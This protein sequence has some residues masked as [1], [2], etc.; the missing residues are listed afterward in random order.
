[1]NDE[2]MILDGIK[3]L[4]VASFIAGPVATTVMAD[5]GAKVIKVEPPAGD[6]Y[7]DL[8]GLAGMPQAE[9]PYHLLVD[10][11]GK[12][13][14]CL[15]LTKEAGRGVLFR[16]VK[17]TDVLVT[18]YM[19]EVREKLGLCYEELAEVNPRL[20]YGSMSAYG[21]TGPEAGQTGFDTTAY[22]A[23]SGLMD[24]VRP[25]PDGDPARSMPGQGDHPTGLA[26]FSA[27]LLALIRRER[28]GEGSMVHSSLLA[29]GYWANAYM[30]QAALCGAEVPL[31][32]RRE[33]AVNAL[34]NYYKSKD[35][36][37]LMLTAA[38]E[39]KEWAR[40]PKALGRPD[41]MDD[42][43]FAS[44]EERQR[45]AETL[46][47]ILDEV[48]G[49]QD[50][51]FWREAFREYRVTAGFVSKTED[52]V[53]DEQAIKSGALASGTGAGLSMNYVIDSPLWVDGS[54]KQAP[55]PAPEHGE[56][57]LEILTEA[58]Y[59]KAGIADLHTRGAFGSGG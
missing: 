54:P 46:T 14:L 58:G 32:P 10:N 7:R 55:S 45:N 49:G 30:A 3:V 59:D 8:P 15:D 21:E 6:G 50:S 51:A 27:I 40:L 56:H 11:R 53:S 44:Q 29:N 36:R 33:L 18:N 43:R 38:N 42:P 28:T 22:W 31:R 13:G 34:S 9:E 26:L 35:G 24:L 39:G 41:L 17:D 4:D 19:P 47:G 23:R 37:W 16:L 12:R 2:A 57:N 20:I 52:I 1:M 25:D 5:F 48:I